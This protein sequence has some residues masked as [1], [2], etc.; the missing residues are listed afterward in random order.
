M[1]T[2]TPN[3]SSRPTT[4]RPRLIAP[5]RRARLAGT[6]PRRG[7]K[8]APAAPLAASCSP[9]PPRR[10]RGAPGGGGGV[11]F[12]LWVGGREK[13]PD[14]P[15]NREQRPDKDRPAFAPPPAPGGAREHDPAQRGP[16]A[17]GSPL[18]GFVLASLAR[19]GG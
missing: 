4:I 18:R 5:P 19:R 8:R 13:V 10:G 16:A 12:R 3:A 2:F 17:P 6:K 7:G 1:P 11:A 15:A 9:A 14:V